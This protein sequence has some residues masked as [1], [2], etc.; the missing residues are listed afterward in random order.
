LEVIAL[1]N[2]AQ[3]VVIGSLQTY[4]PYP[5]PPNGPLPPLP[6]IS[7]S[8]VQVANDIAFVGGYSGDE[9]RLLAVD[10][11]DPYEPIP[12]GY[13]TNAGQRYTLSVEGNV[14]YFAGSATPLDIIQTPFASAPA[15]LPRLT[16][17]P[18]PG[19]QLGIQ[20]RCGF[21]YE[22]ESALAPIG[23]PWQKLQTL[24]LT[25]ETATLPIS[26]SSSN[27]FFRLRQLD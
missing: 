2:P 3:P 11:R 19:M 25:N 13:Y 7:A 12:V 15:A 18:P 23:S 5:T 9:S 1:T 8:D 20:G 17:A 10:V 16:L 27:T 26:L 4:K 6:I 22:I 21:H 24:F 14:V